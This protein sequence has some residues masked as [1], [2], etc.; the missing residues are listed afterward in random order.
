MRALADVL[1][2][3]CL[4]VVT[5]L[6]E[7]NRPGR[8]AAFDADGTLWRSDVGEELLR[9]LAAHRLLPHHARDGVYEEYERILERDPQAAYVRAVEYMEGLEETTLYQLCHELFERRFLGR[10]FPFAQPL[11]AALKEK[12]VEVVL[13]SASPRWI[14]EA[15]ARVFGVPKENVIAFDAPVES[16]RISLP[17]REPLPVGEGKVAALKA[18]GLTPDLGVGNGELDEPML[19][20]SKRALVIAPYDDPGNGLVQAARKRGWP[21]QRG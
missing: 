6:L 9:H 20:Y 16:G 11:L 15:G 5:P 12:Q 2:P 21:V 3:K 8:V 14:V 13:V 19:A 10:L 17:V 1:D 18:R 7:E 4:A